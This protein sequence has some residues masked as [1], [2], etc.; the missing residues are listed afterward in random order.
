MIDTMITGTQIR[1]VE[2]EKKNNSN[3]NNRFSYKRR[4]SSASKEYKDH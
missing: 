3:T 1:A 4:N 2:V